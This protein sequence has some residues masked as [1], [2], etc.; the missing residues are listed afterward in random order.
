MAQLYI[1]VGQRIVNQ[2]GTMTREFQLYLQHLGQQASTGSIV[3][4]PSVPIAHE[5]LLTTPTTY[6]DAVPA[7]GIGKYLVVHRW[8]MAITTTV[9][10]TNVYTADSQCGFTVAY[11]D[12]VEDASSF[13][14]LW[15]L[16]QPNTTREYLGGPTIIV[17]DSVALSAQYPSLGGGPNGLAPLENLPLK[18]VAWNNSLGNFTGGDPANSGILNVYYT[19]EAL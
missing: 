2:D 17:P 14:P 9:A 6:L 5:D 7:P 8:A 16:T 11:G 1:Q 18:L 12:W 10:Y 13:F 3:K 19:V 15:P 4:A